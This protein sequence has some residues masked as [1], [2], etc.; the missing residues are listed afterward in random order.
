MWYAWFDT[1]H[2][3]WHKICLYVKTSELLLWE[4]KKFDPNMASATGDR[5]DEQ[6]RGLVNLMTLDC[7]LQ[8]W[9]F[10]AI[11]WTLYVHCILVS[12]NNGQ[13]FQFNVPHWR[14]FTCLLFCKFWE[15]STRK[16]VKTV[17]WILKL[18]YP[19]TQNALFLI[20][21]C[22]FLTSLFVFATNHSC[23]CMYTILTLYRLC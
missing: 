15:V 17:T 14:G 21:V 22:F 11:L 6:V 23:Q 1:T 8:L 10:P 9:S 7:G 12:F 2:L 19:Q 13:C 5:G 3:T 16:V 20:V 4:A 18:E